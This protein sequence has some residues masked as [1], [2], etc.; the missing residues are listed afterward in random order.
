MEIVNLA[1]RLV[2]P[3]QP[4]YVI[5]EIGSNHNGDLDLAKKMIDRAKACGADAVKFQ[6]WSK[7]SL[8]SKAEYQ[9][10][11]AYADKKRHFGSLEEMVEKYQ[12]TPEQHYLIADYCKTVDI[13]FLS[14]AFSPEE[15]DLLA[16]MG[17]PAIKIASMDV[18]HLP[19]LAHVG[20][21]GLP[22]MLSTGMASLGEVER[23]VH[24]LQQ[25]GSGAVILLHCIS[26]YP[27]A[28]DT[29][30]LRNIPMLQT[31]FDLPVGFSDHSIGT[32]I[33][34][35]AV[36][37][38]AC[39]IEKHFTLDKD[40]EGWDHW[41]S[42]DP[43]ELEYICREGR[44][45]FEALGSTVRT[46]SPAEMEKRVKFRRRMVVRRA[47]AKAEVLQA[48]DLDY[49]R[50]GNGIHPDELKYVVGRPVNRDLAA[51]DELEWGDL[52]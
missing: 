2:G 9:R 7:T 36:A 52:G 47:L 42:A 51:D 45:V 40:M 1:G 31:A 35:A 41:I 48:E 34:V 28:Y 38:G 26:I 8:I 33:P 23:A 3:G 5:A 21:A 44:N 24:T 27:P 14:S 4:P 25:N 22:V 50:P 18:T 6:S 12:F 17:V 39:V 13:H 16:G 20:R 10:N 15:V 46:V 37:L 11:T 43:A 19:L 32:S 30:H 29:I 49:K